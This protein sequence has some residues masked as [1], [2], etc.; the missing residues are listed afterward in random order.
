MNRRQFLRAGLASSALV[1]VSGT[2]GASAAAEQRA[3]PRVPAQPAPKLIF[4]ISD[5]MSHGV[6]PLAD[7]LCRERYGRDTHWTR[8]M[9]GGARDVHFGVMD[10]ASATGPV[11]D[12]AAAAASWGSGRRIPNGQLNVDASGH[13]Y[14][15]ILVQARRRGLAAGLVTTTRITHATPAGFLINMKSRGDEDAIA[16]QYLER[17][18]E[19]LLGGGLRHF[20]AGSRKDGRD[21]IAEFAAAR[22]PVLRDRAALAKAPTNGRLV[23][24]FAGSHLPYSVD[25]EHSA[26]LREQVPSLAE[27]TQA[28]LRQLEA[29]EQGFLLQ[30][31]GGRVDHGAHENDTPAA[32]FDQLAFDAACRAALEFQQRHPETTLVFTTDH[33]NSNPGL[34]GHGSRYKDSEQAAKSILHYR[35]SFSS[36]TASWNKQSSQAQLRDAAFANWQIELSDKELEPLLR[37]LQS[38]RG[39]DPYRYRSGLRHTLSSVLANHNAIGWCGSTHTA[40]FVP[41]LI[42]GQGL[43]ALPALLRN[44]DLHLLMKE[45]IGLLV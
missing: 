33:G 7:L 37:T 17:P 26:A 18:I 21:L 45:R 16:A 15:P 41:L 34:N 22:R 3:R 6:L 5:G 14:E 36:V 31:E 12:S 43:P 38:G 9:R 25:H 40:D 29:L 19:V 23:G 11:T 1:G 28:A 13:A 32:L 10:M 39:P 4:L 27:M 35:A 44:T 2:R 42:K 24:L 8:C 20:D 30:V